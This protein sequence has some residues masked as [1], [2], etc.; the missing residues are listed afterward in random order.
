MD[1]IRFGKVSCFFAAICVA[2]PKHGRRSKCKYEVN[3]IDYRPVLK[4]LLSTI[5]LL[6]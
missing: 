2:I 3:W 6:K 1:V 4:T 5:R